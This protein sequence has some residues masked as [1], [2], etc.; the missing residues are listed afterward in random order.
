MRVNIRKTIWLIVLL[1][2]SLCSVFSDDKSPK[3]YE[4][5]EFPGFLYDLRRAEIITLGAMPFV[6]FNIALGYSFTNYALHNF[7]SSYFVNPFA[8]SSDDNA[9]S[10][11]EQIAI[12]ISSLCIS[13]GIGLTDFIVHSAKRNKQQ[14]LLKNRNK[15]AIEIN[16]ILEDPDAIKIPVPIQQSDIENFNEENIDSDEEFVELKGYK[17]E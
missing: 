9:Y 6:T 11:D 2:F 3:P 5:N 10:S 8:N 13:A 1:C 14:R 7:N 4:K 15:G 16:P 17:N 12:I